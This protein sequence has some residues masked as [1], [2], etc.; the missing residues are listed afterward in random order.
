M[1]GRTHTDDN[2]AGGFDAIDAIGGF[3]LVV[4]SVVRVHVRDAQPAAVGCGS[5][6]VLADDDAAFLLQNGRLVL[7]PLETVGRRV[8]RHLAAQ[9]DA[10]AA[11]ACRVRQPL[12]ETQC[13]CKLKSFRVETRAQIRCWPVF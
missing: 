7:V 10:V 12:D 1:C 3:A 6:A 8:A 11:L 9:F 5:S 4:A 2:D 13:T